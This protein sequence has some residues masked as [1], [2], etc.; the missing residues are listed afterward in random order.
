M[1]P[2][3]YILANA[4]Y[5][6]SFDNSH[7][8]RCEVI[9]H[10]SFD[11]YSSDEW[12]PLYLLA[13]CVSSLEKISVQ[14]LC[15]FFNLVVCAFLLLCEFFIYLYINSSLGSWFENIFCQRLPF[16][17]VD[18]WWFLLLYRHFL[19]WCNP[20]CF[21][22]AFVTF[23]F[24]VKSKTPL[25]RPVSQNLPFVFSSTNFMV[26]GLTFNSFIHFDF[27]FVYGIR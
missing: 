10:C 19:V 15:P 22:F 3:L 9:T 25:S 16:H 5:L 8:N 13:I 7:S 4:Y 21:I 23:T 18:G 24:G 2:Y 26:S 6:L 12:I 14:I 1:F 27:I 17:I 20:I 11:L